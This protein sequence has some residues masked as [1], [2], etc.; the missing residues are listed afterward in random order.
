MPHHSDSALDLLTTIS[1]SAPRHVSETT[2]PLLF[3]S[4]PDRA[5]ARDDQAARLK[6]WRTLASLTKLCKQP[7]LFETL[8]VRL[9]T[10]LDLV[11]D[12]TLEASGDMEPSAAYAHSILRTIADV[13]EAKIKLGHADVIKYIDRLVPRVYYLFIHSALASDATQS[14]ATEPRLVA[15]AAQVIT[16]VVQTLSAQY[17]TYNLAESA[18]LIVL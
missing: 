2:L 8:V 11:C 6:Y 7:D 12:S 14:V 9:L 3:G 16:L 4:L 15:V 13:L 18:Y 10:K 1:A 5:P 17:V